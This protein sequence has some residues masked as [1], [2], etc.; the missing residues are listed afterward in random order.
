MIAHLNFKAKNCMAQQIDVRGK[1]NQLHVQGTTP[2]SFSSKCVSF[3][4]SGVNVQNTLQKDKCWSRLFFERFYR[5]T[6]RVPTYTLNQR[7][8]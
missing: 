3:L 6:L 8:L 5:K 4:S 1:W 2:H 7:Y